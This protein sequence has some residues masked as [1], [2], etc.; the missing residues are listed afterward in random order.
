MGNYRLGTLI[1]GPLSGI[2]KRPT[3]AKERCELPLS[4]SES[5]YCVM[6]GRAI[7]ARSG[8]L[9]T[10]F[11]NAVAVAFWIIP[12]LI[13]VDRFPTAVRFDLRVLLTGAQLT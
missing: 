9:S 4:L 12:S 13:I 3:R 10:F 7:I 5:H 11:L 2:L 8:K 6:H 1:E